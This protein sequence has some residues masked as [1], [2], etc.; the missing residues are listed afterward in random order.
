MS[1]IRWL[2]IVNFAALPAA[3]TA[4]ESKSPDPGNPN[5][6]HADFQYESVFKRYT[7]MQTEDTP[8]QNWHAANAEAGRLGGHAGHIKDQRGAVPALEPSQQKA[9][10]EQHNPAPREQGSHSGMRH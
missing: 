2:V 9:G 6:P 5:A 3:I 1:F 10:A 8:E 7:P 4:T